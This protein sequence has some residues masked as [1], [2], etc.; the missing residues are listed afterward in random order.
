MRRRLIDVNVL[1]ALYCGTAAIRRMHALR[2]AGTYY[3]RA[4]D[5]VDFGA[6]W[7]RW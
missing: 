3:A 5:L 7:R 1:G 4:M 2:G 6:G